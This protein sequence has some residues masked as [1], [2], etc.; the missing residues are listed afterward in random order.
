M[1]RNKD[2]VE[3]QLLI[4]EE[5]ISGHRID[6]L[7]SN[8]ELRSKLAKFSQN[9]SSIC[10]KLIRSDKQYVTIKEEDVAQYPPSYYE[11]DYNIPGLVSTFRIGRLTKFVDV[12][13][14]ACEFWGLNKNKYILT[15]E[16]FNDLV[17]YHE[18]ICNFF[19]SYDPLNP[20][21][22]AIIYLVEQNKF[23]TSETIKQK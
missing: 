10:V 8:Y 13:S 15:D 12:Y 3:N 2:E 14:S 5:V 16:Y 1:R 17:L 4:L 22:Q 20:E 9:V 18:T 19:K 11:E 21:N 6:Q 7:K 23:M